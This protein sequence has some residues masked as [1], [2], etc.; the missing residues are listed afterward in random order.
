[1]RELP[2]ALARLEALYSHVRISGTMTEEVRLRSPAEG[3]P[4]RNDKVQRPATLQDPA[5]L[6]STSSRK[7]VLE[8]S[9][10]LR[11][12]YQSVVFDKHYDRESHSLRDSPATQFKPSRSVACIG[13]DYWFRLRW[14]K[15][16]PIVASFGAPND[17]EA[18][19]NLG[20]RNWHDDFVRSLFG[21]V[22]G[23]PM[24]RIM[25]FPSFSVTRVTRKPGRSG[26]NLVID[27]QYDL[28]DDKNR[29]V[30]ES[31][32][33]ALA[34]EGKK[35]AMRGMWKGWIEFS[36]NEAWAVQARGG[37]DSSLRAKNRRLE[38]EYGEQRDGVPLPSRITLVELS[39]RTTTLDVEGTEFGPIPPSQFTLSAYGLP[40]LDASPGAKRQNRLPVVL[41]L[42][43]LA[44]LSTAIV[45]RYCAKRL[46]SG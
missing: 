36:P 40:E 21:L 20:L 11:K 7:V 26:D 17:Q 44:A 4:G 38:I 35:P 8:A 16:A 45:L 15:D 14:E 43:A 29:V 9:D 46:R 24:S 28:A 12:A 27:F 37:G 1:M 33:K 41:F 5:G 2:G 19:E 22:G 31:I 42:G 18:N 30:P 34:A 10:G 23:H 32:I 6:A 39:G 25:R 3:L 13:R